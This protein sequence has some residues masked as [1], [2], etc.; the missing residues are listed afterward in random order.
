MVDWSTLGCGRYGHITFAPEEP[1]LRAQMRAQLAEGDAWRCL[2]CGNFIPGPPARSGPTAD[3]PVV[4]RGKEVRS[5]VILRLFAVER[6]LRALVFAAAA[7]GLWRF[8]YARNSIEQDF[9]RE[10]P[11][12]RDLFRQLG[13]NIDHSRLVGLVQHALTLSSRSITILAAAVAVYAVIEVVE[14]TGLWLAR[15][16]GEYFA[17]IATSVGLPLEIY[18]LTHKVT[19]LTLVLLLVNLALVLYLVITKRLFGVRG[20]KR[21]YDARLRSESVLEAAAREVAASGTAPVGAT[22]T[23][24]GATATPAGATA[25][26]ASATT[27]AAAG[28]TATPA[29]ATAN[30][31]EAPA[32]DSATGIARDGTTADGAP[33]KPRP[34]WPAADQPAAD[35]PAADQPAADQ[36]AADQ[37]AA[38]Q[39][40][41]S[42]SAAE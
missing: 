33:H 39:S 14:G 24:A 20:G 40:E 31:A 21:A 27:T 22:A 36:P 10:L 19:A 35:Q 8:R 25:A 38:D 2:R 37:P 1:E 28:A 4:P 34:A 9:N 30:G 42:S 16:W 32:T 7:F 5:K 3:A 26:P 11:I 12:V 23:P 29:S 17:M 41:I 6:F 15:R 13:Y 18:D